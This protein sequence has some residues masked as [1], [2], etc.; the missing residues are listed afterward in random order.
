MNNY[1]LFIDPGSKSTG[2]CLL[3][4]NNKFVKSGSVIVPAGYEID[5]RLSHINGE[6]WSLIDGLL[7]E[8][9]YIQECH[10]ERMNYR[11]HYAVQW[12]IGAII[13]GIACWGIKCDADISPHAW[14][15]AVDW[16]GKRKPLLPYSNKVDSE[17]ELASIGMA[18]YWSKNAKE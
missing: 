6:Y 13:A 17:D 16:H 18:I 1:K 14:Q 3:S 10:I 12:S 9:I 8:G 4:Q 15:K 11:V 5:R 7:T 2:W